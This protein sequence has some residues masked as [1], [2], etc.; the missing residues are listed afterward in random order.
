M[1]DRDLTVCAIVLWTAAVLASPRLLPGAGGFS[2][3]R[4]ERRP[5]VDGRAWTAVEVSTGPA[6][7]VISAPKRRFSLT[8]RETD[9]DTGDFTRYEL[10][11]RRPRSMAVRVDSDFTGW[12][13]ITPDSRFVFSEPLFALDVRGWKQYALHD[14]LHIANYTTIEAISRDR[15][16]LLV[17]RRDCAMDC[18]EEPVDEYFEIT[19]PR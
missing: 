4:L 2:A 9:E 11:F 1:V 12:V 3:V 8:L 6:P 15:R 17:S 14:A 7:A 18:R 16:R 13:Y 5:Q 19:V 10:W